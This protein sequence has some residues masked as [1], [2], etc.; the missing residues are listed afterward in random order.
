MFPGVIVCQGQETTHATD[1]K[2]RV[3]IVAHPEVHD[4][5]TCRLGLHLTPQ[6]H[7]VCETADGVPDMDKAIAA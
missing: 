3:M 6:G 7:L 2:T 1:L 5:S 4:I